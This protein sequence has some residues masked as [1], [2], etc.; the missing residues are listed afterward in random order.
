MQIVEEHN[1]NDWSSRV[2]SLINELKKQESIQ[3]VVFG[4]Q[5]Q[6]QF[7]NTLSL[8]TL[9]PVLRKQKNIYHVMIK[10]GHELF[11]TATPE[12]LIKISHDHLETAAV[13]GT[14]QR[15]KNE[16]EDDAFGKI[17]LRSKK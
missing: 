8:T 4:R 17:L 7:S 2:Q 15:G 5:Q 13:A 10:K 16:S 9:V 12:R 6:L 14:I 1:E 3:K 11:I